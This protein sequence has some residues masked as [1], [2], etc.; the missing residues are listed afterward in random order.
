MARKHWEKELQGDCIQYENILQSCAIKA[1]DKEN[2]Q[3]QVSTWKSY[4]WQLSHTEITYIRN[5]LKLHGGDNQNSVGKSPEVI[6]GKDQKK[7]K[8]GPW[9]CEKLFICTLNKRNAN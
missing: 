4:L 3:R 8:I 2:N 9:T 1:V 6:N 5:F 7:C